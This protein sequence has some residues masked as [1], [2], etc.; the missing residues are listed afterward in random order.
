MAEVIS[1]SRSDPKVRVAIT[2]GTVQPKPIS[3]G[4]NALPGRPRRRIRHPPRRRRGPDSRALQHREEEKEAAHHG[5]EGRHR[6]Q[7]GTTPSPEARPQPVG[8]W[9]SPSRWCTR[10]RRGRP[11]D[12]EEVDKGAAHLDGKHTN[13]RYITSRKKGMPTQGLEQHPVQ[14]FALGDGELA[15]MTARLL[16]PV[17]DMAVAEISELRRSMSWAWWARPTRLA[18]AACWPG[19]Q[20]LLHGDVLLQQAQGATAGTQVVVGEQGLQL[21]D[22][23]FPGLTVV[24]H[25]GGL[26]LADELGIRAA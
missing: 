2:A 1:R 22:V 20:G 3:M 17:V 5:D 15:L 12:V 21:G 26:G 7:T 10:P 19:R 18:A 25:Q 4:T 14:P 16:A 9:I 8:A 23:R 11:E 24:E 6:L 13:I